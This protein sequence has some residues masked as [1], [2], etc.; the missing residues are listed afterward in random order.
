MR[1][2]TIVQ[3]IYDIDALRQPERFEEFLRACEC[4]SRGRLG[5]ADKPFPVANRL[6]DYLKAAQSVN[7]GAVAALHATPET[8]KQ[9]VFQAR[10]E[11]IQKI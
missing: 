10:V 11:A 3:F 5:Y 4:D 1:P 2:G 7:A 6:R 9:A 8:I